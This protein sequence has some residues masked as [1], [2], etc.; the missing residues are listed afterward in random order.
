MGIT[1]AGKSSLISQLLNEEV[2]IIGHNLTS[3]TSGVDFFMFEYAGGR[4][5]FLMDTPGFDDTYRS[6]AE[7]LRDIAFILAQVYRHR[8]SVAGIIYMH[9]ITDNRISGSSVK[10]LEVLRKLCGPDAF[11]RIVLTTSMWNSVS[12]NLVSLQD[13]FNRENQLKTTANFWG[14]LIRGGSRVMRWAGDKQSA[15]GAISHLVDLHDRHG[16]IVLK[17]QRELVENRIALD[18]T[19]SGRAVQDGFVQTL[20]KHQADLRDLSSQFRAAMQDGNNQIALKIR[21]LSNETKGQLERIRSSQA[22][23]KTDLDSLIRDK[24]QEYSKVLAQ[25]QEDRR[26]MEESIRQHEEDRKRLAEEEKNQS[27]T[28][29]RSS[30]RTGIRETFISRNTLSVFR[31]LNG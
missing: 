15:V 19:D 26:L 27:P 29:R 9:R 16:S 6:N 7:V 1:G 12:Q 17:I 13:A 25:V 2:D 10:N 8:L 23:M 20:A 11:S 24:A 31:N 3:Y 18:D 4:R 22:T 30:K 28:T 14:L 5:V 21:E